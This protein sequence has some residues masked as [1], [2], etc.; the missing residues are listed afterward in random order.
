M[1]E[2]KL[3]EPVIFR[4]NLQNTNCFIDDDSFLFPSRRHGDEKVLWDGLDGLGGACRTVGRPWKKDLLS[5]NKVLEREHVTVVA[6]AV[7]KLGNNRFENFF[8]FLNKFL[9]V[10]NLKWVFEFREIRNRNWIYISKG[11][12]PICPISIPMY[13][14]IYIYT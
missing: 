7:K 6:M 11:S 4:Q 10:P 12:N 8:F 3:F 1:E 14:Y 5:K 2:K 9:A 13:M